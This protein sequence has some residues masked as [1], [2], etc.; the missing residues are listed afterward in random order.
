LLQT[1]INSIQ[2]VLVT[3]GLYFIGVPDPVL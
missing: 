2:G 3:V 1:L